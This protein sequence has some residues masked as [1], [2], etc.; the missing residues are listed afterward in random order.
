MRRSKQMAAKYAVLVI[1]LFAVAISWWPP[2]VKVADGYIDEGLK[3]SLISF[4]SARVLNG[5]I[6]V[7]QGTALDIQPLGFGVTLAVGEILDP[8][9]D[10]VES[11]STIML[12][13]SVAFGIQKLLLAIG[14]NWTVSAAL[15]M[16]AS[17]WAILFLVNRSPQWLFRLVGVL[18]FIR[19]VM[20]V[21]TIGSA[22]LFEGFSADAYAA[23]QAGLDRTTNELKVLVPAVESAGTS[24][25]QRETSNVAP[26]R[27]EVSP[28][29]ESS[30][31]SRTRAA[32]QGVNDA[33]VTIVESAKDPFGAMRQKADSLKRKYED[34][35]KSAES[36][37]ERMITL[38]VIFLM[39]TV[40]VPIVLLLCLY[41]LTKDVFTVQPVFKGARQE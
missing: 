32:W 16:I 25:D 1:V 36:A 5:V 28:S 26:S 23:S 34:I 7:L 29:R 37:V 27:V 40:I 10:L 11:F 35:K 19:F 39:Q 33:A 18:L 41:K 24:S 21:A 6:S 31:I 20:P 38:I 14:A 9:N 15:T 4:A 3:R 8:V 12:T 22:K 2:I 17:V 30:L 13:A